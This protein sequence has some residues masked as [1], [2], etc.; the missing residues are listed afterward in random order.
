MNPARIKLIYYGYDFAKYPDPNTDEVKNIKNQYSTQLL[1]TSIAR[2][3]PGKRHEIL[4]ETIHELISEHNLDIK[5][6][7]VGD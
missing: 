2:L 1:L 4:F 6:L 5:L 3:V 7:V